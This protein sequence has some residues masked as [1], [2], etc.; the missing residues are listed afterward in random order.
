[1]KITIKEAISA[2]MIDELYLSDTLDKTVGIFDDENYFYWITYND[3]NFASVNNVKDF[4]FDNINFVINEFNLFEYLENIKI[5]YI[6]FINKQQYF[7]WG[8]Y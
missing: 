5:N 8:Y 2:N 7:S 4:N 6:N 1:M 3:I